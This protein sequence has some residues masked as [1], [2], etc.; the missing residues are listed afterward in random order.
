MHKKEEMI[1]ENVEKLKLLD[2]EDLDRIA[3][4][5]E[6]YAKRNKT[7]IHYSQGKQYEKIDKYIT[8]ILKGAKLNERFNNTAK[9]I[10]R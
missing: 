6:Q 8:R 10:T 5:V 9:S 1:Y 3:V 4:F 7:M 2:G